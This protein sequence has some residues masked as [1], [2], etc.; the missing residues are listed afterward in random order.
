MALTVSQG[1]QE[2]PTLTLNLMISALKDLRK[3]TENL[4][5]ETLS[6]ARID[7]INNV[8]WNDIKTQ[9]QLIFIDAK[10]K[11]IICNKLIN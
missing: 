10:F 8:P 5:L 11:L 9:L 6:I 2:D 1:Q 7:C 3:I 4:E